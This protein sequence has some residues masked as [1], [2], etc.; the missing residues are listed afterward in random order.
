MNKLL[1]GECMGLS[2]H[3]VVWVK[4]GH[5]MVQLTEGERTNNHNQSTVKK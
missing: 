4:D 1:K 5:N 2:V 3:N